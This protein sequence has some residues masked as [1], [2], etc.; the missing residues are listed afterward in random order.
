MMMVVVMV[1]DDNGDNDDDDVDDDIPQRL[2]QSPHVVLTL[3]CDMAT[4]NPWPDEE[5]GRT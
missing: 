1:G 3:C 5:R 4:T 2:K